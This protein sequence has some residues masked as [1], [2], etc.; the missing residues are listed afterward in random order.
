MRRC[1]RQHGRRVLPNLRSLAGQR[2]W[3][4][5]PRGG[6]TQQ[7]HRRHPGRQPLANETLIMM[8]RAARS[9]TPGPYFWNQKVN[10]PETQAKRNRPNFFLSFPSHPGRGYPTSTS[11]THSSLR[12][13]FGGTL[14]R[15]G[16]EMPARGA[17]GNSSAPGVKSARRKLA[18]AAVCECP[19]AVLCGPKS[20]RDCEQ[21]SKLLVEKRLTNANSDAPSEVTSAVRHM[22]IRGRSGEHHDGEC[23]SRAAWAPID[24]IRPV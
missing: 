17:C 10:S 24:K 22:S 19:K 18:A 23:R 13:G 8:V 7:A 14:R 2:R 4:P 6:G 21:I 5:F 1:D 3:T 15:R 16:A 11:P 12:V 20:A 9:F